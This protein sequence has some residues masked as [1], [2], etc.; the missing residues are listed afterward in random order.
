MVFRKIAA[1]AQ[2]TTGQCES[3]MRVE[4]SYAGSLA[5]AFFCFPID[6]D[7]PWDEISPGPQN[8]QFFTSGGADVSLTLKPLKAA[9]ATTPS[10]G[11]S[12]ETK[13]ALR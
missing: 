9:V 10:I 4:D 5:L 6:Q 1:F 11:T 13:S 8:T 3:P 7:A 12:R 2:L